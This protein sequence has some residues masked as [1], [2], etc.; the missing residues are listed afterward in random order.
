MHADPLNVGR[1]CTLPG[2]EDCRVTRSQVHDG[3]G[4]HDEPY[5]G[6]RQTEQ[7][8]SCMACPGMTSGT[9]RIRRA[10]LR[11]GGVGRV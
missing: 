10:G 7:S 6:A 11:L 9:G 4:D 2:H 8:P 5:E 1:G 3:K